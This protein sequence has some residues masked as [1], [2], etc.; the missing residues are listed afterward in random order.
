MSAPPVRTARDV[1]ELRLWLA[2]HW[3]PGKPFARHAAVIHAARSV[4]GT[5]PVVYAWAEREWLRRSTLWWVSESMVDL[6]LAS[7]RSVPDDVVLEDLP[8]M[9][10]HGLIVFEKPWWGLDADTGEPT[11]QVDAMLWGAGRLPSVPERGRPSP[12]LAIGI[13]TYRRLDF[14]MGLDPRELQVATNLGLIGDGRAERISGSTFNLTG[15]TW[16]PLGR[17]DWPV[18]EP[19]GTPVWPMDQSYA[20]SAVED[21]KVI[22]AFWTLMHTVGITA[23]ETHRAPRAAMR[24]TQRAGINGDLADVQVVTLRKV[25]RTESDPADLNDADETARIEWSHRWLV[26]GHWRWQPCG[27]GRTERRLTYVRPY[28]KGPEDKPLKTPTRVNAWV[29]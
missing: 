17:S 21:R 13:A 20:E 19:I 29:R 27:P 15:E 9:P 11:L 25:H 16:A 24:R 23:T 3:A 22:A 4:A 28:V 5:D 14:A 6:L 8:Q 10:E 7:A 26:A 18:G 2:D 1:A 12:T